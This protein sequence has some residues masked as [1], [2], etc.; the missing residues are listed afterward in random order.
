MNEQ[1]FQE[2]AEQLAEAF[3]TRYGVTM[4]WTDEQIEA[5]LADHELPALAT[6]PA[7]PR[8]KMAEHFRAPTGPGEGHAWQR[9]NAMHL[10]GHVM[11]H[12]GQRCGGCEDWGKP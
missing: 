5:A 11:L 7:E 6:L 4:A 12:D 8:G 9:M 2:R 1:T 3:R 10:L